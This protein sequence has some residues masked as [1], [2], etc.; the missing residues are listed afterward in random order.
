M[1]ESCAF[2]L[3]ILAVSGFSAVRSMLTLRL[4][5]T[6][7]ACPRTAEVRGHSLR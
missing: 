7:D 4:R 2:G 5:A 3:T 6:H 1:P